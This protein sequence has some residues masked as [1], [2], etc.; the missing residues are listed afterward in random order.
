[1]DLEIKYEPFELTIYG[2]SSIVLNKDYGGTAFRLMDRMWKIVKSN[3]LK[4]KGLNIW[5]YEPGERIFA[6]VE[7]E[8]SPRFESGL[9][10]KH[11][12]LSKY[13][14]HKHIGSYSLIKQAGVAMTHQLKEKGYETV[15]RI[16][17]FTVTGQMTRRSLRQVF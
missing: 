7:L 1:L 4:N 12:I 6:G 2:F 14:F 10:K 8:D 11:I 5:V 3:D 15:F 17:K 13:A 16:L 9:E